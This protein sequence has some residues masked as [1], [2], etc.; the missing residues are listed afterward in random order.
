MHTSY[1]EFIHTYFYFSGDYVDRG[2]QSMELICLLFLLK[3]KY[4]TDFFLLR[5][6]HET[7]EIN[8]QYGFKED[9]VGNYDISTWDA[10]QVLFIFSLVFG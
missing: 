7:A 5:G 2:D 1:F 8:S 4:P 6:N 3:I 10:F 9:C